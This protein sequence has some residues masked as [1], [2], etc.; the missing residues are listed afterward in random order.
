ML[1]QATNGNKDREMLPASIYRSNEQRR[2]GDRISE[3]DRGRPEV[4]KVPHSSSSY[5]GML[6]YGHARDNLH[7][8]PLSESYFPN[9]GKTAKIGPEH[10]VSDGETGEF[11]NHVFVPASAEKFTSAMQ[12]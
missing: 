4:Q 5:R 8:I 7:S 10:N 3:Q 12:G 1:V 11:H 2:R 6:R 9:V